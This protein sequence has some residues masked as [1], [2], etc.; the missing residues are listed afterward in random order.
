MYIPSDTPILAD[1]A[2]TYARHAAESDERIACVRNL[3]A[4]GRIALFNTLVPPTCVVGSFGMGTALDVQILQNQTLDA[5]ASA[6]LGVPMVTPAPSVTEI[7]NNAPIVVPMNGGGVCTTS[8]RPSAASTPYMPGMPHRAPHIHETSMGPMYYRG[9]DSTV[10]GDESTSL[11]PNS[12]LQGLTG[13]APPWSDAWVMPTGTPFTPSQ[14]NNA[15][16]WLAAAALGAGIY[17]ASK[18]GRR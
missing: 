14:S 4:R 2:A 3:S 18:R 15:I 17:A 7:V 10:V 12:G 11:Y 8:R 16:W 6:I 13:Y 5:R 1:Q 9:A